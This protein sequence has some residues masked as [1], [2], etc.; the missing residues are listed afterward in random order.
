MRA[1]NASRSMFR[2]AAP[3]DTGPPS[4]VGTTT[5][6]QS[7]GGWTAVSLGQ[8]IATWAN[9]QYGSYSTWGGT[10][11]WQSLIDAYGDP[12]YDHDNQRLIFAC[13]GHGDLWANPVVALD[14]RTLAWSQV[15]A[16][17]PA[18]KLPPSYRSNGGFPVYPSGYDTGYFETAPPL[19]DSADLPY[20]APVKSKPARH[21]YAGLNYYGGRCENSYA[22]P[23]AINLGTA[24]WEIPNRLAYPNAAAACTTMY[25]NNVLQNPSELAA[26]LPNYIGSAGNAENSS[27]LIDTTT[28]KLWLSRSNGS[29]GTYWPHYCKVDVAT[30]AME[31]IFDW[32]GMGQAADGTASHVIAGRYFYIFS[33]VTGTMSAGWRINM[34]TNVVEWLS[35]TGTVPTGASS[36]SQEVVPGFFNGTDIYLW[37]YGASG[38]KD[39]LYEIDITPTGGAGTLA[40][41]YT[42]GCTRVALPASGMPAPTYR[43]RL[44]YITA[45]GGVLVVPTGSSSSAYFLKV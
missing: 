42:M 8:S 33:V 25:V 41:P 45:W 31:A 14:M 11:G 29:A 10:T 12:A 38:D 26:R 9:A 23:A 39:A 37:N 32:T 17:T 28:G 13:G 30:R 35:F 15:I 18:S 22:L 21:V 16:P 2:S 19:T 3:P 5:A 40:S 1:W 24:A 34:D 20:A 43:Y 44:S 36:G 4:Y 6:V 27:G 7:G